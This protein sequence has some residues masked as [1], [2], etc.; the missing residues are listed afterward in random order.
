MMSRSRRIAPLLLVLAC[1]EP[2]PVTPIAPAVAARVITP[3]ARDARGIPR[4]ARGTPGI[5]GTVQQHLARIAPAYGV[6]DTALPVFSPRG[7]IRVRGGTITR[8]A[9][10][11]DGLAVE[12]GEL[13]LLVGPTGEL[14]TASGSIVGTAAPRTQR[15][16]AGDVSDDAGAIAR[17]VHH[18]YGVAFDRNTLARTRSDLRTGTS[19]DIEVQLARAQQVWHRAGNR[20]VAAWLVETYASKLGST[21]GDAFRTVIAGDGRVLSH[22]SLTADAAFSY[23]VFADA[24]GEKHPFDGPIVDPTPHPTGTPTGVFPA[25]V[26]PKLVNVDGLNNKGGTPDPWLAAGATE[27]RGNN[28]DAYVDINAPSGLSAG[29]FRAT[30]TTAGVFDRTYNTALGPLSSQTQQMAGVTS[31]FYSMNWLHDFWYDAGFTEAAGNG[32]ADNLGRG[33]VDGD[34]VLAEAQDDA[35]GGSRNN[36]NMSTPSDGMPPRMQVFLWSGSDDKSLAVANRTPPTAT[37][38]FGPKSFDLT[39][40]VVVAADGV[41]PASDACTAIGNNVT[42]RIVLVDRGTCSF[43]SKALAVQ[44]AGG[45][46]MILVD[47][48]ASSSPP[49][50]GGDNTITATIT[51]GSLSVTMAEGA[52]IK[53]NIAAGTTNATL[54]RLAGVELDGTLDSTLVAHEFGHYLHHRLQ[55]CGTRMCGALSEGWGDFLALMLAAR[56]GDNLDGAYPFAVYPTVSFSGDAAYFGIRRAP[57]SV[58]PAINALSFRH[59]AE[60]EPTPTTHPFNGFGNNSEVHNAGEIWAETLWEAYVALQ[61]AGTDFAETRQKMAEY[62]VAGLLLAPADGSPTET[63]DAILAAASAAN[64]ADHD[65][66]IAA[67]ARR[68][69]GSCAVSPP[70]DSGDFTGIVESSD[71]RGRALAGDA[72]IVEVESCDEDGVL[73]AGETARIKVPIT[74]PGHGAV[75]DV[76]IALTSTTPGVTIVS[77]PVA[78]GTLAPYTTTDVELDL[79][80]D[81]AAGAAVDG[82]IDLDVTAT[83]SC[84]DVITTKIKLRLNIDEVPESSATDSFDTAVSL[85]L[86]ETDSDPAWTQVRETGLDSLW[87]GA[88]LGQS[89][90]TNLTSPVLTADDGTLVVTFQHRYSFE[91]SEGTAFDGG[92]IEISTDAGVTWRDV[93]ELGVTPGYSATLLTPD[94]TLGAR[95]AFTGQNAAYPSTEAATLDFGTQLAGQQFQIRFRIGTDQGVG[96]E[97]WDVDD[98][99][100]A[101]IVGTPFPT[102]VPDP[103][104]CDGEPPGGD[105]GGGC[106][107]AGPLRAGHGML[108][109]LVLG[110]VARRRRRVA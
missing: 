98:I 58:N 14:L 7:E 79:R 99:A 40:Q 96:A 25:F 22:R 45:S 13:R 29:D 61:K 15:A 34:A 91:F 95:A 103:G 5:T 94:N 67:F 104:G 55:S 53:A 62:V 77:A 4:L 80:L 63:R 19:G 18:A 51:I 81:T 9:Q 38:A 8:V 23:R 3:I 88:D 109:L 1:S 85:W 71:V 84:A 10:I 43:K 37:A 108:A 11:I 102:V 70:A 73:D 78:L 59:M 48:M 12:D 57:Y 54:H 89:S 31:L 105:D 86:P 72:T 6:A 28:V 110:V 46:G 30:P 26:A 68:G 24:T 76:T 97:G 27:S 17:A 20:L 100:F 44:T 87:H 106:C 52:A 2:A 65:V 42:G 107:D 33:G 82:E 56:A 50:M 66:L 60:G 74:N 92:V 75:T 64:Q 93:S 32:Q 101:G 35:N 16:F 36:A 21:N 41:A 49:T 47:N 83:G 90:D 39:G 69:M